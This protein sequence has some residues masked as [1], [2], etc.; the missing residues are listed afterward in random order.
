MKPLA[1]KTKAKVKAAQP[2]HSAIPGDEVYFQHPEHGILSGKVI[3]AGEHGCVLQH[4]H[5]KRRVTW[6]EVHGHKKRAEHALYVV[7]QGEDGFVAEDRHGKRVFIRHADDDADMTKAIPLLFVKSHIKGYTRKDGTYVQDHDD[8]RQKKP[9]EPHGS[10][11]GYGTHNIEHGDT[12]H[13]QAG[14]F[15]GSGRVV[16]AGEHGATVHDSTGREHRV[17][18]HE[19]TGK[20]EQGGDGGKDGGDK[21]LFENTQDLPRNVYQPHKTEDDLY[22]AAEQAL[23]KFKDALA[24]V[25]KLIGGQVS[26][27]VEDALD[28]K[29]PA[30]VVAPLKG[31]ERARQKVQ[32][33]YAGNWDELR[34]VLR[35]TIKCD[36]VDELHQAVAGLKQAGIEMAKAPKN[37]FDNPTPEGYRDALLVVKVPGSDM[38]AEVQLHLSH[39][40]AAKDAGHEHYNTIRDI[41][42]KYGTDTGPEDHW[43]K[44]DKSKYQHAQNESKRLY[45]EAWDKARGVKYDLQKGILL[46]WKLR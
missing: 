13:F 21:P 14:E 37:R 28:A 44:D 40:L 12:V 27:T 24:N 23:P 6:E 38:L 8:K 19:V 22:K 25:A 26:S 45:A 17:H 42:A 34:D 10:V 43:H 31:K 32:A 4:K 20:G 30:V 2:S 33:D 15:K 46:L 7:D 16:A 11:H 1:I 35:A 9:D 18:W 29:G 5:G 3:S 36:S 41:H 39:V